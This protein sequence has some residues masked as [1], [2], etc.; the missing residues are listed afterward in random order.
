MKISELPLAT[1]FRL[2]RLVKRKVWPLPCSH[3]LSQPWLCSRGD[4]PIAFRGTVIFSATFP[5][6]TASRSPWWQSSLVLLS[7]LCADDAAHAV[8]YLRTSISF[9][10]TSP[11]RRTIWEH[12]LRT[13]SGFHIGFALLKVESVVRRVEKIGRASCR[14]RV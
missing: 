10:R 6:L 13:A 4:L 11:K 5:S 3:T 12:P 8:E 1:P 2:L 7:P 9:C 14:E